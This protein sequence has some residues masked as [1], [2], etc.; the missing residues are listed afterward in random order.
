MKWFFIAM[1]KYADFSGRAR[2]REFWFYMLFLNLFGF[3]LGIVQAIFWPVGPG[4]PNE[5]GSLI[6]LLVIIP[7]LAVSTRRMHDTDR[8]GWWI[9]VPFANFYFCMKDGTRGENSYGPD[10]KDTL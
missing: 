6:Q 3:L 4:Q 8:M 9:L 2:R 10:P 5:F 1:S 7:S